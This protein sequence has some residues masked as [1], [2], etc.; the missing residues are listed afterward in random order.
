MTEE[1]KEKGICCYAVFNED[2]SVSPCG[3]DKFGSVTLPTT[4]IKGGQKTELEVQSPAP[5]CA[6]HMH[7]VKE[8]GAFWIN[9]KEGKPA[10]LM[11]PFQSVNMVE[12]VINAQQ[13]LKT[14]K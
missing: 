4:I 11:G 10:E 13:L 14:K 6:Y 5:F 3:A 7:I 8:S 9:S 2:G 12:A 1:K